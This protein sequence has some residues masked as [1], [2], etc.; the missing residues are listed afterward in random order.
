M[1]AI[2][3][4][5][6]RRNDGPKVESLFGAKG[7]CGGCWCMYWRIERHG[8]AWQAV[9]G[10]PNR[11]AL[12]ALIA[13]GRVSAVLAFDG[14][15]P[16]GWCCVGPKPSFS[17]LARSRN[18][19]RPA[20]GSVW[21]IVCLYIPARQRRQGLG[22]RLVEAAAALAFRR[23]AGEVEGYPVV[24]K[25]GR[26]VSPTFAWTGVPALFEACGFDACPGREGRRPIYRKAAGD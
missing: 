20:A 9:K 19:Q 25:P 5:P 24:P 13:A 17:K 18:L 14:H 7:A 12:M 16:I 4:R 6:L 22:T 8:K 23:G 3:L 21:S 1:S 26:T 2:A 15:T 10:E 11:R